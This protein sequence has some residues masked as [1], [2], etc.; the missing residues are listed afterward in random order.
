VRRT[1][2]VFA[3]SPPGERSAEGRVTAVTDSGR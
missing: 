2:F 1:F 3:T